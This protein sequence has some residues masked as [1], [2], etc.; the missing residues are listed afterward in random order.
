MN[1]SSMAFEKENIKKQIDLKETVSFDIFDTLLLRNVVQP[2]D[3]FK[4]VEFE[5]NQGEDGFNFSCERVEAETAVRI[6]NEENE[7]VTFDEIYNYLENKF[8]SEDIQKIKKIELEIEKK[9]IVRNEFLYDIYRYCLS[10][11]KQILLISD[12]YLPGSFIEELIVSNG[13]SNYEGIYVSCEYMKTKHN[14][15]LYEYVAQDKALDKSEWIHIGDNFH[16][17]VNMAKEAGLSAIHYKKL[18]ERAGL[19]YLESKEDSI[20]TAIELNHYYTNIGKDYWYD[21]GYEKVGRLYFLLTF[22]LL[23]NV[24]NNCGTIYFLSRDGYIL[25]K[26]YEILVGDKLASKLESKYLYTS[27]RAF[28]FSEML[29]Y[30]DNELIDLLTSWNPQFDQ[31]LTVEE[32]LKS[33]SLNNEYNNIDLE[34]Y[35]I[36]METVLS[37]EN[38]NID[39]VKGFIKSI[40][41][42]IKNKLESEKSLLIDYL[43]QEGLYDDKYI[44]IFDI[45][46]RGSIQKAMQRFLSKKVEGYYFATTAF[47]HDCVRNDSLGFA[48]DKGYPEHLWGQINSNIM[49][50]E[51]LFSAPDGSLIEFERCKNK[52]EPVLENVESNENS[53]EYISK[54]Q[55]AGLRYCED[56]K[57]YSQYFSVNSQ[58]LALK[59]IFKFLNEKNTQDL[60]EFSKIKNTV[61]FGNSDDVKP[62]VNVYSEYEYLNHRNSVLD[63][64]KYSLWPLT[65]LID[66]DGRLLSEQEYN[67]LFLNH[68]DYSSPANVDSHNTVNLEYLFFKKVYLYFKYR[69][70]YAGIKRSYSTLKLV[71]RRYKG[72]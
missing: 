64:N 4:L 35:G 49:M 59:N 43:N 50:F 20:L 28:Q 70:F 22:W 27:R 47:T 25:K 29:S 17:D 12:M 16:A 45:G 23:S 19:G 13:Y 14:G 58:E 26:I 24:K 5:Y 52:I 7:D 54:I 6:I 33:L 72:L 9:F 65:S 60:I 41:P 18:S 32:I 61:G 42:E 56:L 48:V 62:Y 1:N 63:K 39:K 40:L 69:G 37:F 51:M 53:Y 66:K 30:K 10:E 3:I 8:P 71:Y 55:E 31:K 38:G 36:L 34:E 15:T 68:V 11:G 67:R 57:K 2:I 21:F 46:W 44:A